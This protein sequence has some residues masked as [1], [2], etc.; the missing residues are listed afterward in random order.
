MYDS[1]ASKDGEEFSLD[2]E[3]FSGCEQGRSAVRCQGYLNSNQA[4]VPISTLDPI[5]FRDL[6][7]LSS[8]SDAYGLAPAFYFVPVKLFRLKPTSTN[9][10]MHSRHFVSPSDRMLFVGQASSVS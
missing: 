2:H 9:A 7:K 10:L 8:A 5:C 4:A 6:S 1:S 3:G